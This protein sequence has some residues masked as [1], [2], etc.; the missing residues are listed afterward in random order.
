ML[1]GGV[2][3]PLG[4]ACRSQLQPGARVVHLDASLR[5]AASKPPARSISARYVT[6]QR[7]RR[8]GLV[9][10]NL[11]DDDDAALQGAV[12]YS[13]EAAVP[14]HLHPHQHGSV[15]DDGS[16]QQR[17]HHHDHHHSALADAAG[18]HPT[19]GDDAQHHNGG[20]APQHTSSEWER[21]PPHASSNGSR[22][23]G[24]HHD[25][26]GS[27][28]DDDG[29][30]EVAGPT[31]WGGTSPA[32]AHSQHSH[33][34][35]PHHSSRQ[36]YRAE[37]DRSRDRPSSP[38]GWT[39]GETSSSSSW[40]TNGVN[41][42]SDAAPAAG[43][44]SR[45]GSSTDSVEEDAEEGAWRE[46]RASRRRARRQAQEGG[47]Q[48]PAGPS[49]AQQGGPAQWGAAGDG[50]A[51][52]AEGAEGAEGAPSLPIYPSD[53]TLLSRSETVRTLCT[54]PQARARIVG[55]SVRARSPGRVRRVHAAPSL[56][57]AILP[58]L[59]NG[60]QADYFQPRGL[61]E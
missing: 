47:G 55:K 31:D 12:P 49:A 13:L 1:A 41:G 32:Q 2:V 27:S 60:R 45:S 43:L 38:S 21:N 4:A 28:V 18:A 37:G 22:H 29:W 23:R 53:I 30:G 40:D 58:V 42:Y 46:W 59:P 57:D 39:A 7:G 33:Q 26:P 19:R 51:Y 15:Q 25:P 44:G 48:G 54:Q 14:A 11:S 50:S 16:L 10:D 36:A 9:F 56:Q 5:C 52:G 3:A 17:E 34:Q 61:S 6:D 20:A 35:Q 24:H 8:R